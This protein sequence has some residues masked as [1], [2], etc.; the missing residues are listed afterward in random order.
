VSAGSNPL[1]PAGLDHIVLRVV[2]LDAM[3]QFYRDVI[4]CTID[5]E[6]PDLGLTHLRAGRSLIDLITVDGP[7]GARG[8]AAPGAEG[9]NLEHI[10]LTLSPFDEA[11]IRD[12]LGAKGVEVIESGPRYGAE[13]E[14]VSLYVQDPEGTIVELKSPGDALKRLG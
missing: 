7:L 9:R 10:C 6:R 14:G 2:D 12:W 3:T 4:G 5:R 1:K 8:G 13:G 11:A